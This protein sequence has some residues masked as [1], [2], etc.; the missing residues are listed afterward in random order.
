MI[1]LNI[2]DISKFTKRIDIKS[3]DEC[4]NWIASTWNSGYGQFSFRKNRKTYSLSAHRTSYSIFVGKIPDGLQVNHHCDNKICVNPLH[5]YAGTQAEN[6]QDM[7]DRGRRKTNWEKVTG[8]NNPRAK[9][10][11]EDVLQIRKLY[12]NKELNQYELAR[13]FGVSQHTIHCIVTR[14]NWTHI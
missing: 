10:R 8:Q 12:L 9:L 14:K 6:L 11:E 1:E 3:N 13:M 4:W 2:S 5:L 7:D